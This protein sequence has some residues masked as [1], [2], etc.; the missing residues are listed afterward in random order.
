MPFGEASIA[1]GKTLDIQG[2]GRL[3]AID[4]ASGGEPPNQLVLSNPWRLEPLLLLSRGL[5]ARCL[6]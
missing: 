1:E 6:R 2:L 5:L 4:E 3:G